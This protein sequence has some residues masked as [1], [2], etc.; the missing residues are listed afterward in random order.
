M[1]DKLLDCVYSV[2]KSGCDEDIAM[3]EY[4]KDRAQWTPTMTYMGCDAPPATPNSAHSR[5]SW[6]LSAMMAVAM[7]AICF[8]RQV[9]L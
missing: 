9:A 6:S 4:N 5:L 3:Y 8:T 2:L 1:Q 7:I